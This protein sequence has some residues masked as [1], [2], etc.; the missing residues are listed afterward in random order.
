LK[1]FLPDCMVSLDGGQSSWSLLSELKFCTFCCIN[2]FKSNISHIQVIMF[3]CMI[4]ACLL[5]VLVEALIIEWMDLNLWDLSLSQECCWMF[6]FS[7]IWHCVTDWV[8]G[9]E[10]SGLRRHRVTSQETQQHL[11]NM[12][13]SYN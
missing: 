13:K 6:K 8:S 5:F 2:Y 1:Q 3:C 9:F 12:T 4:D 10:G 7:W 11:T